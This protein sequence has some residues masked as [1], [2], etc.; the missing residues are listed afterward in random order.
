MPSAPQNKI[1]LDNPGDGSLGAINGLSRSNTAKLQAIFKSSPAYLGTYKD[2]DTIKEYLKVLKKEVNDGGHTFGTYDPDYSK[3]SPNISEVKPSEGND[4]G[5]GSPHLP[6]PMSPGP[7]LA[8]PRKQPKPPED[9]R[10]RNVGV[11]GEGVGSALEPKTSS[12]SIFKGFP[13][14]YELGK[15]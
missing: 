10:E 9:M 14:S 6:N 7:G 11:P 5:P 2:S 1:E 3:Q 8:D 4:G 15:S 13:G 12:E